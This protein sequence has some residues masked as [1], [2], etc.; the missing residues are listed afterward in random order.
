VRHGKHFEHPAHQYVDQFVGRFINDVPPRLL[1]RMRKYLTKIITK[2]IET[3]R[4][5]CEE[6]ESKYEKS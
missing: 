6:S 4:R 5:E 2:A 1:L 3:E